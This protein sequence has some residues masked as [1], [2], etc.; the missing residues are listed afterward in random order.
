[1][2]LE[3]GPVPAGDVQQWTQSTRRLFCELRAEPGDLEGVATPDLLDAWGRLI[4]EWS[5]AATISEGDFRWSGN[6]DAEVASYLLHGFARGIHSERVMAQL[7]QEEMK[8]HRPF[9]FHVAQALVDGLSAE[10]ECQQ[11][12]CDQ[13]RVSL[14]SQLE[15]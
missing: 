15:H 10:G 12:L 9:T 1:M 2:Y 13:V 5:V 14:Q 6:I 3:L 11:Q 8:Q 4:D 7:T